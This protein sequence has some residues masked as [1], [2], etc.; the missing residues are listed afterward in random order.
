MHEIFERISINN[1]GS[2]L[3]HAA[4]YKISRDILLVG[5]IWAFGTAPLELQNAETKRDVGAHNITFNKSTVNATT[6]AISTFSHMLAAQSL[7]AGE[8][9]HTMPDSRRKERVFGAEGSGRLTHYKPKSEGA[10]PLG[11]SCVEAFAALM[12]A[13]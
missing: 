5:D 8:S 3:P 7:R 6:M 1:H 4:I 10:K 13:Q 12:D 11:M 2:Y 9:E